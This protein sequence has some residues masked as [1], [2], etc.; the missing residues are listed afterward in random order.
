MTIR[1]GPHIGGQA[2]MIAVPSAFRPDPRRMR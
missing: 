1:S 2:S